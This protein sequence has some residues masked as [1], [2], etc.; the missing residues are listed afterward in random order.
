M[1]LAQLQRMVAKDVLE[2]LGIVTLVYARIEELLTIMTVGLENPPTPASRRV[3]I[4]KKGMQKKLSLFRNATLNYCDLS[5][6]DID[7]LDSVIAKAKSAIQT[8]DDL[9]HGFPAYEVIPH[10]E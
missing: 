10:G 6:S 2:E 4:A 7:M 9:V 3:E 1:T 5:K 8:R